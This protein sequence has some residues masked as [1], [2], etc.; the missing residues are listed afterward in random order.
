MAFKFVAVL[1]LLLMFFGCTQQAAQLLGKKVDCKVPTFKL[2]NNAQQIAENPSNP[3]KWFLNFDSE[4]WGT[5]WKSEF[6]AGYTN[7]IKE[8]I[9]LSCKRGNQSGE[10][11][12]YL[13]CDAKSFTSLFGTQYT[14]SYSPVVARKIINS[15]G[16]ISKD[17][18][19]ILDRFVIDINSLEKVDSWYKAKVIQSPCQEDSQNDLTHTTVI[20]PTGEQ[21]IQTSQS[22]NNSDL[23][24]FING[25]NSF[26]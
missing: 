8:P 17:E 24:V 2:S 25:F 19:I 13:Y 4:D 12:N 18:K 3:Y 11:I 21:A 6:Y 9:F 22:D 10:N 20:I 26:K 23:N 5:G 7:D 16:T 14:N 15:N 1:L